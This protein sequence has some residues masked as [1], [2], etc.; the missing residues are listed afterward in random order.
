MWVQ[1]LCEKRK[2]TGRRRTVGR[3]GVRRAAIPRRVSRLFFNADD[4]AID[5]DSDRSPWFPIRTSNLTGKS[6]FRDRVK[7][8]LDHRTLHRHGCLC[9]DRGVHVPH[10]A[11]RHG[12]LAV[13]Y[14]L[15]N[16][17]WVSLSQ[18]RGAET[19]PLRIALPRRP[20]HDRSQAGYGA[21][22]RTASSEA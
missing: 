19:L 12:A 6:E 16:V 13:R 3:V 21:A 11:I 18:K 20:I 5:H 8:G 9:P 10:G 22:A 2:A 4:R 1:G 17:Q 14:F 7:I 15:H